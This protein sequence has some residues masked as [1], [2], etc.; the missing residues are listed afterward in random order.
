MTENETDFNN[1]KSHIYFKNYFNL[2]K[3]KVHKLFENLCKK[4]WINASNN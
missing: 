4:F 1:N 3:E 2:L